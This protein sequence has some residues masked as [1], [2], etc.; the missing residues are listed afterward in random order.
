MRRAVGLLRDTDDVATTA[1]TA[2]GRQQLA[3]LVSR[4]DGR[5]PE[6]NLRLPEDPTPWPPEV[7]TTVHRIV[8]ESLTSIAR[9]A[10]HARSATVDDTHGPDGVTVTVSDDAPPGHTRP[11]PFASADEGW[12]AR[13]CW[14]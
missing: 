11:D 8:Q 13:R 1:P 7:A 14:S 2:P 4:F 9:H 5:G 3:E 12:W 6:V 10:A